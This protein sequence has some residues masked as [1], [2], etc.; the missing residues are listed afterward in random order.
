MQADAVDAVI[1]HTAHSTIRLYSA[2]HVGSRWKIQN[3]RQIKNT[4]KKLNTTPEKQTTK[5]K[6]TLV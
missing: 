4:I 2:I 3:G 1:S 5:N 6:T